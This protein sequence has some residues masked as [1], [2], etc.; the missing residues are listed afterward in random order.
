MIIRDKYGDVSYAKLF[1][2]LGLLII[3]LL[4]VRWHRQTQQPTDNKSGVELKQELK[5][6]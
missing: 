6:E 4:L 1:A 2:W 3:G 5:K